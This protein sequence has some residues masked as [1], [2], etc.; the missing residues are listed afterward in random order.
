M[1]VNALPLPSDRR[2]K[3]GLF[4]R[5]FSSFNLEK[6]KISLIMRKRELAA[7]YAHVQHTL[8]FWRKMGLKCKIGHPD[9]GIHRCSNFMTHGC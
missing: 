5:H 2:D 8:L 7:V 4:N 3:K 1:S 9:N 6:S